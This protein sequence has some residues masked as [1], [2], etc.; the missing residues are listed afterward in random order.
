V[1]RS[2]AINIQFPAEGKR[3]GL[4]DLGAPSRPVGQSGFC[5][6][7]EPEVLN[8]TLGSRESQ[9]QTVENAIKFLCKSPVRKSGSKNG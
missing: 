1:F 3:P 5:W 8:E 9:N 6:F 7:G 2:Q 4:D